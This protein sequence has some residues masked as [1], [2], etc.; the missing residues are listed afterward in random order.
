MGDVKWIK[1][2][3]NMFEDEKVKLID[4]MPER[5]TIHYIWIRLLVQAG[6]TNA[7][8]FIFL[9]E[10]IPYDEE[11]LATIFSRPINS[12]RLALNTLAR[13]GMIEMSSN[14]YLAITNWNK[15][16]NVDGLDK[17]RE[18]T[19]K[20]VLNYR[21]KQKNLISEKSSN[22]TVPLPVTK[23][24]EIE[25]EQDLELELELELEQQ[26][27]KKVVVPLDEIEAAV[28]YIKS[29]LGELN[30][31]DEDAHSIYYN[32]DGDLDNIAQIYKYSRTQNI[33]NIV[34]WLKHM[35]KPGEF[36][37]PKSS[38]KETGFNNFEPRTY[39]YKALEDGLL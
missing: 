25:Q 11:M 8:G 22:V 27:E 29:L 19:R 1:I 16:Q 34:G 3:T 38:V 30:L 37:K 31:T 39:D 6:K 12:I 15:H 18:Q 9:A 10:N 17:I 14:S 21:A 4:A 36:K 24:N 35:V 33:D 2:T 13:F 20:R 32:A 26:E 5:D 28:S 23:S 7:N